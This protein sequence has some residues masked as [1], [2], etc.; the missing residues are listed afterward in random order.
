MFKEF[1][2]GAVS[3][4]NEKVRT[5][6][7]HNETLGPKDLRI[8]LGDKREGKKS[9]NRFSIKRGGGKKKEEKKGGR[10]E[11]SSAVELHRD[12]RKAKNV[13][14]G[15]SRG[16]KKRSGEGLRV[17]P[18]RL[19]KIRAGWVPQSG[20][21]KKGCITELQNRDQKPKEEISG[22][23]LKNITKLPGVSMGS[24]GK[25]RVG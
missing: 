15:R 12:T 9:R 14:G 3:R 21:E 17:P 20:R 23:T 25:A 13:C 18:E 7:E 11:R 22:L 6:G 8:R 4:K 10:R 19:T 5:G 16:Q 2:G 1:W 24:Q